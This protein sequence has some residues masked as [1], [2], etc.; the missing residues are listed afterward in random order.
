[1]T[2]LTPHALA[3]IEAAGLTE[4]QWARANYSRSGTWHGDVCGCAD[5]RCANGFHHYGVDDCGC[6]PS[7]LSDWLDGD[8][9]RFFA[10]KPPGPTC[11]I[12]RVGAY[13]RQAGRPHHHYAKEDGLTLRQRRRVRHKFNRTWF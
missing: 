9:Y 11:R 12:R 8:P 3:Q 1:V 4:Q 7:M 5:D 10:I 6:L 13:N 2:G